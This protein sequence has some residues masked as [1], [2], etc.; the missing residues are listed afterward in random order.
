[1][2]LAIILI[3]ALPKT[4]WLIRVFL[5]LA[6]LAYFFLPHEKNRQGESVIVN[7]QEPK[8]IPPAPNVKPNRSEPAQPPSISPRRQDNNSEPIRV[9]VPSAPVTT[10]AVPTAPP[11]FGPARWITAGQAVDVAGIHIPDGMIYVGTSLNVGIGKHDPCLIDPSKKVGTDNDNIDRPKLYWLSYSEISPSARRNYLKWLATGRCD[12]EADISNVFLYF[13]GFER[14]IL[15]DTRND[16]LAPADAPIIANEIRRLLSIYGSKSG[17]FRGYAIE[18][19]ALVMLSDPSCKLYQHQIPT[20]QRGFGLPSFVRI[21]LGQAALD[22]V[23]V[24]AHVALAWAKLDENITLRTPALRCG[25]QFDALF[26][27]KYREVFS[28]GFVLPQNRTKLTFSYQPASAG[29]QGG[30]H[31]NDFPGGLPDVTILAGSR[32]KLQQIVDAATHELE[33]YSRY[34]GKHPDTENTLASSVYLPVALWPDAMQQTLFSLK[35]RIG[36]GMMSISFP[37]LVATFGDKTELSKDKILPLARSLQSVGVGI[38]P[39]VLGGVDLKTA[40]DNLVLFRLPPGDQAPRTTPAYQVAELMLRLSSIVAAADGTFDGVEIRHLHKTVQSW[41]HL[42]EHHRKRLLAHLRLVMTS[43]AA[44]TGIK[45]RVEQLDVKTKQTISEQLVAVAQADGVLT[46]AEITIL[47]KIYNALGLDP[48]KVYAAVHAVEAGAPLTTLGRVER[49][50]G[51]FTLDTNRISV[52][53]KESEVAAQ[54]LARIFSDDEVVVVTSVTGDPEGDQRPV[55]D[56]LLGLDEPHSVLARKLLSQT[57][58]RRAELMDMAVDLEL[59]LD[60]ALERI[61]EASFEAYD[62]PFIEGD[63]PIEINVE[64]LERIA[65]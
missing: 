19:L 61:N 2:I 15:I 24:P 33:P 55:S 45:K 36:D 29:F 26:V 14:R 38:E 41:G 50:A 43:P 57:Q 21:A 31:L 1:M 3:I 59:M 20:L 18:L 44:L 27:S 5:G 40:N 39:D 60:G 30:H 23:P 35:N 34:L 64:L 6:G 65:A 32:K 62:I 25:A 10:F 13:Y 28:K 9:A 16:P 56:G 12:P 8:W 63:D 53:Q 54:I 7:K 48:K 49:D 42:S 58:W 11:G 17:S 47:E 52:L 22:N 4:A 37:A 51:I 46:T